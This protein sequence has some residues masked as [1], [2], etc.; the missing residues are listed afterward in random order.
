MTRDFW[1]HPY[2][3]TLGEAVRASAKILYGRGELRAKA[4]R[5]G[6][7]PLL[8]IGRRT[9]RKRSWAGSMPLR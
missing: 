1:W 5:E 8:K 2:D 7:L 6:A 4:L 3:A 9:L